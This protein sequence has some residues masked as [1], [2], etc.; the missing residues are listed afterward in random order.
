MTAI[1]LDGK[2]VP[3]IGEAQDLLYLSEHFCLSDFGIYGV[4]STRRNSTTNE[5]EEYDEYYLKSS[6]FRSKKDDWEIYDDA[7]DILE[8]INGEAQLE[9]RLVHTVN[10]KRRGGPE[11]DIVQASSCVVEFKEGRTI[12]INVLVPPPNARLIPS[13]FRKILESQ[14]LEVPEDIKRLD[15]RSS[16]EAID[17]QEKVIKTRFPL[18]ELTEKDS[19]VREALV[20]FGYRHSWAS[21]YR[22][23]DVI[24]KEVGYHDKHFDRADFRKLITG[25]LIDGKEDRFARTANYHRHGGPGREKQLPE[26]PMKLDEAERFIRILMLYWV[27][28]KYNNSG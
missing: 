24:K 12:S 9:T 16:I 20:Y 23:W 6:S 14:G 17:K 1:K 3:L 10:G 21:L 19:N 27:N 25:S 18:L 15:D 7:V 28:W 11:L 8:M 13:E 2:A 5:E 4:K 22:V 26:N